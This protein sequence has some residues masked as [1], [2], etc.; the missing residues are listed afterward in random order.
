MLVFAISNHKGG[1]GKT[2]SAVN[3]GAAFARLGLSTL[4]VDLDPQANLSQSLGVKTGNRAQTVY[5]GL[6]GEYVP[7]PVEVGFHT[8]LGEAGNEKTGHEKAGQGATSSDAPAKGAEKPQGKL[9][10]IPSTIDLSA[11]EVELAAEAGREYLLKEMLSHYAADFQVAIIDCPPS[12]ALLTL[13]A[14]AAAQKVLVPVQAEFLAMQGLAKLVEVIGKIQ[15]RLNPGLEIGGV[16][17]TQYDARKV[18]SREVADTLEAHFPGQLCQTRIRD[19]V[20]LAEAPSTAQDVFRYSPTAHGAADY[21]ALAQEVARKF[22]LPITVLKES[23]KASSAASG[24]VVG[25]AGKGSA[26]SENSGDATVTPLPSG[27][28]LKSKPV[29]VIPARGDMQG[30]PKV[31]P[32]KVR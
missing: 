13:N 31:K 27:T 1:V 15:K 30:Q 32:I 11:A 4:L 21:L 22:E 29:K 26:S 12:L 7:A 6:R 5:G 25:R 14:L 9:A 17:V 16:F 23:R 8:A 28:S 3:L 2:T 19:N 24:K 20:T 18:L 10:V